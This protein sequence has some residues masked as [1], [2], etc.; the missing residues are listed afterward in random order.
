MLFLTQGAEKRMGGTRQLGKKKPFKK[1][2]S[3]T[4]A[5][6]VAAAEAD[7][8]GEHLKRL[9]RIVAI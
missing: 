2:S 6:G 7:Q 1:S 3:I 4:C 8:H 5:A 9:T